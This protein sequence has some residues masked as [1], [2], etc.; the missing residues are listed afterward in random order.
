MSDTKPEETKE[1]V[2]ATRKLIQGSLA[3][4]GVLI[5]LGIAIAANLVA[6]QLFWRVDMTQDKI[7]T[8]SE[9]S[10]DLVAN[11][12]EPVSVKVFLSPDMPPPFHT[13]Q[14]R[15][16]DLLTE[17]E[18]A[19]G[20]NLTFEV[21][22][23]EDDEKENGTAKEHGCE[24]VAIGQETRN[25]V[26]IRAVYKCVAFVQGADQQ[27]LRDLRV[28][29][30]MRS[31]N[32]EYHF[33]KALL[34]LGV[35]RSRKIAFLTGFGGPADMPGFIDTLKGPFRALYGDLIEPVGVSFEEGSLEVPADVSTLIL[36][37]LSSPVS[38]RAKFAIDQ[39]L[40][41]G[42]AVGWYQ[43]A[44]ATD[45]S[46]LDA[47]ANNEQFKGRPLPDMRQPSQH[48]LAE[49]FAAYGVILQKDILVDPSNSMTIQAMTPQGP[50]QVSFPPVFQVNE[51]DRSLP[52]LAGIPPVVF[53]APSS[54]ILTEELQKNEA[55]KVSKALRTSPE[56]SRHVRF[57]NQRSFET[58]DKLGEGMDKGTHLVGVALEGV[59]PSYYANAPLPKGV[60]ED[61][62]YQG[63]KKS[64][65]LFVVG[66]GD[67]YDLVPSIG[68]DDRL[69]GIGQQ[70][71]FSS[72]EWLAQ[73]NAL[74][75]VRD[76][77]LPRYIGEI[78]RETQKSIQFINILFVPSCFA[79]IG[80]VM[81]FRR[82][83]RRERLAARKRESAS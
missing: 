41:R 69:A 51:L 42:G 8:L 43:S 37:D 58:Y 52:F 81:M 66:S 10:R 57:P 54:I 78:D 64:A 77:R 21:Q 63:E 18:A 1:T 55:I 14:Q 80:S 38:P 11:L 30:N 22:I 71:L 26:N 12:E 75:K 60:T 27:V 6:S 36:L 70:L 62:L 76:K 72:F 73:D 17:Y 50:S 79:L 49:F 15:V 31:D 9:P 67:F 65:R 16:S 39:F 68:F 53:P 56:A 2:G 29:G 20:G 7:Y 45:H 61:Q 23:V 74:S 40:Q 82:R 19:S 3:T 59:L 25:E 4:T 24:K 48:E 28:T 34:N 32:L 44:T 5:A 47:I 46:M 33:T 13:L 83:K 35:E